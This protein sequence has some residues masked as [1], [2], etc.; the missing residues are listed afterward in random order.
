MA[1]AWWLIMP[2]MKWMSAS[3]YGWRR[4]SA[5]ALAMYASPTWA[6]AAGWAA[7]C[8]AP[9]VA[10]REAARAARA[11]R[12]AVRG[13]EGDAIMPIPCRVGTPAAGPLEPGANQQ[14]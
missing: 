12:P 14:Y 3:V 7:L 13:G 11:S 5:R 6:P 4:L 8:A 2:V 10:P 9:R 1:W